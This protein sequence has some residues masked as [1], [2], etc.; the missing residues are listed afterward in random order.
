[1]HDDDITIDPVFLGLT[2]PATLLGVPLKPLILGMAPIVLVFIAT[3]NPL[4]LL[5][6]APIWS[7]LALISRTDPYRLVAA[8]HWF[9]TRAKYSRAARWW[10]APTVAPRPVARIN[11]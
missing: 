2:R 9:G 7:V 8:I 10:G 11:F 4:M 6:A 3:A 1:M 5:L